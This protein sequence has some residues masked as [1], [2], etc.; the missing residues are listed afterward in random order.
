MKK[1]ILFLAVIIFIFLQSCKDEPID[2]PE[3]KQSIVPE[4]VTVKIPESISSVDL[5]KAINIDTLKGERF[6]KLMRTFIYI[7]ASSAD[8]VESIVESIADLEITEPTEK[9]YIA[10]D[11]R[12]KNLTII[13]NKTY[14]E[15]NWSYFLDCYDGEDNALQ[16][17]WNL[18]PLK[19]IIIM[20]PSIIN[21]NY[22]EIRMQCIK[23][24]LEKITAI[25]TIIC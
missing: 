13:A 11:G 17:F 6:Y 22:T 15:Q 24:N 18:N 2:I 4:K 8:V 19:G 21:Y 14:K 3:K 1:N 20:K 9:N 5:Q 12:Q 7:G 23:L 16:I 10:D 25:T